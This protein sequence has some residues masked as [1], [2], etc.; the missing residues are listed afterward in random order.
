[1]SPKRPRCPWCGDPF[2]VD[3]VRGLCAACFMEARGFRSRMGRP[4]HVQF[5]T[6]VAPAWTPTITLVRGRP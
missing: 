1:M 6:D 3:K 5:R 2:P 4:R